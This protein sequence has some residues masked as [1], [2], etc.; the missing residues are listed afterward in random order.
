MPRRPR[1][2]TILESDKEAGMEDAP[3]LI[4]YDGSEEAGHAIDAAAALLGRRRAIVLDIGPMVTAA[5]SLAVLAP[6]T[7][8]EQF[9]GINAD[10]ALERARVGA[11]LARRAGFVAAPRSGVAAPTWEGIVDVADEIDPAVIVL[12]SRGL[13]GAREVLQGSVSHEVAEHAGRPVLI[14]PPANGQR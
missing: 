6:V 1:R 10:D 4:C 11:E 9:A 7:P 13:N 14:V 3:I 12:G 2:A 8:A 5:E